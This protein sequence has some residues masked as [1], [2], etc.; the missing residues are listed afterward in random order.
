MKENTLILLALKNEVQSFRMKENLAIFC[1]EVIS[2]K[3]KREIN[4]LLTLYP[5]DLLITDMELEDTDAI[6]ICK[7]VRETEN[8]QQPYIIVL[9]D[10]P[11]DY[12]QTMALDA[13]ADDFILKPFKTDVLIA[14]IRSLLNRKEKI[15]ASIHTAPKRLVIDREKHLVYIGAKEV[16]LPKKEFN[17]LNLLYSEPEKVFTR[18]EITNQV[19]RKDWLYSDHTIDVYMYNLRKELGGNFIQTIKGVGYRLS[20]L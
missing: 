11:E 16:E 17:I 19:N 15:K 18:E 3:T 20:L 4:K 13:G 10:R 5:V 12:I 8:I 2:V 6:D 9:S 7:E 14:R 1:N